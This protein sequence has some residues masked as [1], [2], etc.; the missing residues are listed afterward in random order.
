MT[1]EMTDDGVTAGI[2]KRLEWLPSH[3]GMLDGQRLN[4]DSSLANNL[5]QW[6]FY[7]PALM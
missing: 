3:E 6:D 2:D 5:S 7:R 1:V 4:V